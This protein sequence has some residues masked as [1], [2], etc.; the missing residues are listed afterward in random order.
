MMD[1]KISM[2]RRNFLER[3]ARGGLLAL[4]ALGGGLLF[5]RRQVT[6]GEDCTGIAACRNCRKLERCDRPEAAVEREGTPVRPAKG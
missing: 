5:T 4:L 2:S 6:L 3:M 1:G